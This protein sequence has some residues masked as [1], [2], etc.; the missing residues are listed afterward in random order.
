MVSKKLKGPGKVIGQDGQQALIKHGGMYVRVHPCRI[1]FEKPD[2]T[3]SE[4]NA[5]KNAGTEESSPNESGK[6]DVVESSSDEETEGR[7][8]LPSKNSGHVLSSSPEQS[9][10]FSRSSPDNRVASMTPEQS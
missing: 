9:G 2:V 8:S 1:M 10:L 5:E 7:S 3:L 6:D 4:K